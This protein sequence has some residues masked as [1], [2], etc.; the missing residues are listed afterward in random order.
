MI[1]IMV[2]LALST[3]AVAGGTAADKKQDSAKKPSPERLVKIKQTP[4][5]PAKVVAEPQK[6]LSL[7]ADPMITVEQQGETVVFQRKTPFG[8]Q[9]W[10]KPLAELDAVERRLLRR[11]HGPSAERPAAEGGSATPLPSGQAREA[12]ASRRQNK[13]PAGKKPSDP[14]VTDSDR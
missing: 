9:I 12:T 7:L 2:V 4:F 13:E 6:P 10:K 5:G 3:L 8:V 1:G 11:E 14:P